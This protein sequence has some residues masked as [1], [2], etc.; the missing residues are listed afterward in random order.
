MLAAC[1]SCVSIFMSS[2][3]TV[4]VSIERTLVIV[5]PFSLRGSHVGVLKCITVMGF[6]FFVI[7][8]VLSLPKYP[9]GT[10]TRQ[11][12]SGLC[13][14]FKLDS[15]QTEWIVLNYVYMAWHCL[16]FIVLCINYT[17]IYV[18]VV[19]S[20]SKSGK[21]S[22]LTKMKLWTVSF[23]LIN[24]MTFAPII[25]EMI[26]IHSGLETDIGLTNWTVM[27]VLPLAAVSNPFLY[28]IFTTEYIA[29]LYSLKEK[30]MV[31]MKCRV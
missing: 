1:F 18:T 21:A 17:L 4:L 27:L 6:S 29:V 12:G 11:F 3:V 20:R 16:V 31:A 25:I 23:L 5:F 9:L 26:L 22:S 28:T 14:L 15:H 2:F 24:I 13:T 10:S 19:Q 7:L 8:V 30:L